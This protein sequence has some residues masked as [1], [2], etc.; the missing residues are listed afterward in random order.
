MVNSTSHGSI[1]QNRVVLSLGLSLHVIECLMNFLVHVSCSLEAF[2]TSNVFPTYCDRSMRGMVICSFFFIMCFSCISSEHA[3]F[4]NMAY[5]R[6][7]AH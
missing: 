6:S 2:N 7:N 1:E 3:G 5:F 4:A